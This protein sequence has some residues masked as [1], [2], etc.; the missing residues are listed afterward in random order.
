MRRPIESTIFILLTETFI[1]Y[2]PIDMHVDLI[3]VPTLAHD[4]KVE[5]PSTCKIARDNIQY[6]S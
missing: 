2:R 3:L 5:L 1:W 6:F 4:K